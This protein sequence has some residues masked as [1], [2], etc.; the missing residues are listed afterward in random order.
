M[1]LNLIPAGRFLMGS[2]ENEPGRNND[3]DQHEVVLTKPF[4]MGVHKVTV[5][6]VR[7][8]VKDIRYRTEAEKNGRGAFRR[9]AEENHFTHG[10]P[11]AICESRRIAITILLRG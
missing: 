2:Q 11:M 5:G 6:Q 8:F 7:A 1:K 10:G 3:E 4:Y 9:F